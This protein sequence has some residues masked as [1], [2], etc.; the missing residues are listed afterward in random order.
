MFYI[1]S[2]SVAKV[3]SGYHGS[4]RSRR[5][6]LIWKQE[7]YENPQL[8][9]TVI[10]S[11]AETR[12][13][14]LLR[15]C[16]MQK[17]M[18]VKYNP[19]YVNR[20]YAEANGFFGVSEK[21]RWKGLRGKECPW[22]GRKATDE[23][24][25]RYI[26]SKVGSKN[27]QAKEYTVKDNFGTTVLTCKGN[28]MKNCIAAGI[29]SNVADL[30]KESTKKKLPITST[31]LKGKSGPKIVFDAKYEG[32]IAEAKLLGGYQITTTRNGMMRIS[33]LSTGESKF[34]IKDSPVPEGWV[35]GIPKE[36]RDPASRW[37]RPKRHQ[38]DCS[39]EHKTH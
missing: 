13:G 30:L 22:T 36:I 10:I 33:N 3:E 20:A 8:F 18:Q 17:R 31:K 24:K 26:K 16:E 14:A 25:E 39:D 29:P 6:R 15:E 27:P 2:S 19:L 23:Q 1:G 11:R 5:Y 28:L 37:G 7:Q 34:V 35:R 12:K 38:C 9:K 32:W 4:V 21:S